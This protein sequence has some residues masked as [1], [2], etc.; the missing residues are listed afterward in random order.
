MTHQQRVR[1]A[2]ARGCTIALGSAC[3]G[4]LGARPESGAQLIPPVLAFSFFSSALRFVAFLPGWGDG[5]FA[6]APARAAARHRPLRA[7]PAQARW[8]KIPSSLHIPVPHL[9]RHAPPGQFV[10]APV[11]SAPYHLTA[12]SRVSASAC[13]PPPSQDTP[14]RPVRGQGQRTRGS[15]GGGAPGGCGRGDAGCAEMHPPSHAPTYPSAYPP[16]HA[17]T[18][19]A[20]LPSSRSFLSPLNR[21]APPLLPQISPPPPPPPP[22]PQRCPCLRHQSGSGSES[23]AG[24]PR[25]RRRASGD[26]AGATSASPRSC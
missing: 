25:R 10:Q 16:T 13:P 18:Q 24:A 21:T 22:P 3:V 14:P 5:G 11:V 4:V 19:A 17:G 26:S 15:P 20:A 1:H 9:F 8:C 7:P 23:A 2:G 12:S 6:R